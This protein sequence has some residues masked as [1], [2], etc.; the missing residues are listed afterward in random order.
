MSTPGR[1]LLHVSATASASNKLSHMSTEIVTSPTQDNQ[2][3]SPVIDVA[4]PPEIEH[5]LSRLSGYRNVHGV[6]VIARRGASTAAD[7]SSADK[8]QAAGISGIV[9]STGSVFEGESGLKYASELERLV[10]SVA[11][12]V[13][14][15]DSGV[16]RSF[17]RML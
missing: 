14:T 9:Q 7:A 5:T 17:Q 15:C 4:A 3:A 11:K 6:M 8:G 12:A 16:S 13:D 1:P 2:S 10:A